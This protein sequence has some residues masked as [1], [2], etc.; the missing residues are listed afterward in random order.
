MLSGC[1]GVWPLCRWTLM[2]MVREELFTQLSIRF[3]A[4]Y[5]CHDLIRFDS[6]KFRSVVDRYGTNEFV[7]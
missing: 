2:L 6:I 7:S 3:D 5:L 4:I 1:D